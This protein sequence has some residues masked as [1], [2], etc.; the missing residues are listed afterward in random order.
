MKDMKK[1]LLLLCIALLLCQAGCTRVPQ[2]KEYVILKT[3]EENPEEYYSIFGL[4]KGLELIR[5]FGKDGTVLETSIVKKVEAAEY[6]TKN[7]FLRVQVE[8]EDGTRQSWFY[9]IEGCRR[10]KGFPA[11]AEYI[12]KNLVRYTK[13]NAD[14]AAETITANIYTGEVQK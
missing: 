3:I 12:G 6:E 14:G 8:W 1:V 9:E 5:V 13:E 11:D 4:N 2:D 7:G 10:S